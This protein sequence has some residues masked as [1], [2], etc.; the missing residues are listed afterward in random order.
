ME[1]GFVRCP[2]EH[3]VY[4]KKINVEVLIIA[5]YIDDILITGTS[6]PTF[7]DFKAQMSE[8]FE[9]SDL[10]LLSHYLGIEIRQTSGNI[11]L[12]QTSYAKRILEK[13]GLVECNPT[14]YP[15]DPK[16]II[17][18]DEGGKEVDAT[19]FKSMVGGLRYLVHTRPKI[20]F[21]VGIISRF[22]EKPTSIHLKAEKRILRYVKR[23]LQF[24][25]TYTKDCGNNILS[26]YSDSD[27]ACHIEDRRSTEEWLST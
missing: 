22:M 18:R 23:T 2:Y 14:R 9:M 10:G 1:L 25:L 20:A 19:V 12:K 24:G 21:S 8:R 3:A 6:R 5:I 16:E 17:T 11:E 27:L 7:D 26:G 15:M 4:T 13:A